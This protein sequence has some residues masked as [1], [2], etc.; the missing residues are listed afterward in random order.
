MRLGL[1]SAIDAVEAVEKNHDIS[2][3]IKETQ[4]KP[5]PS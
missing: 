5:I 3:R 4:Q 1:Y 2:L